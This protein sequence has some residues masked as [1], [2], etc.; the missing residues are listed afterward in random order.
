MD[1]EEE[2]KLLCVLLMTQIY[3]DIR[4][5]VREELSRVGLKEEE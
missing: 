1:N 2:I 5:I 3:N 4:T